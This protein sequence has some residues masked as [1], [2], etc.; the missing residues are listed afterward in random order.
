MLERAAMS[1]GG[2]GDTKIEAGSTDITSSV[3]LTYETR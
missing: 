2:G 3:T 1:L